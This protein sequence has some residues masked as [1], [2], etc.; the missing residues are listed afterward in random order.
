MIGDPGVNPGAHEGDVRSLSNGRAELLDHIN[1]FVDG[2][3]GDHAQ[4]NFVRKIGT[5]LNDITF[6]T[7]CIHL[8]NV[9]H[10]ADQKHVREYGNLAKET[11]ILLEV[12]LNELYEETMESS[13]K[14]LLEE[15]K[16]ARLVFYSLYRCIRQGI[17]VGHYLDDIRA[18]CIL[19]NGEVADVNVHELKVCVNNVKNQIESFTD[20]RKKFDDTAVTADRINP[21]LF[22]DSIVSITVSYIISLTN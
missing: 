7:L 8:D 20:S 17:A 10:D 3:A 2:K 6:N 1:R 13:A 18:K 5:I 9:V 21:D 16:C 11:K 22:E 19:W 4:S 14:M 15:L 12:A